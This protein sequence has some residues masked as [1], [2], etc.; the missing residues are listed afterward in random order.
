MVCHFCDKI[1]HLSVPVTQ[2]LLFLA[3]RLT[4]P[5]DLEPGWISFC[6]GTGNVVAQWLNCDL[7]IKPMRLLA[8]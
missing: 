7:A 6:G 5:S 1:C 3:F 2:P 4:N 8:K